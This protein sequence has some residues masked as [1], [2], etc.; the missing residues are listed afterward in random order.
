MRNGEQI[1]V[2]LFFGVGHP[3]LFAKDRACDNSLLGYSFDLMR[4]YIRVLQGF[5]AQDELSPEE[6]EEV[7]AGS[8]EV[9]GGVYVA[10]FCQ[11]DFSELRRRYGGNAMDLTEFVA[12]GPGP[13]MLFALVFVM[14]AKHS[15]Q[16]INKHSLDLLRYLYFRFLSLLLDGSPLGVSL[17]ALLEHHGALCPGEDG[18]MYLPDLHDWQVYMCSVHILWITFAGW[19]SIAKSHGEDWAPVR[20]EGFFKLITMLQPGLESIS[21]KKNIKSKT[22][23]KIFKRKRFIFHVIMQKMN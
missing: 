7:I 9:P 20:E 4:N 17:F 13:L 21:K 19:M 1:P 16:S 11:G 10:K 2:L 5:V 8:A 22:I 18:H 6:I 3:W 23:C 12:V 15:R 14:S